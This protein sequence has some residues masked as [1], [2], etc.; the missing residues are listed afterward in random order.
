MLSVI[1]KQC[2]GSQPSTLMREVTQLNWPWTVR[3]FPR[4]INLIC[5]Y[6]EA[7]LQSMLSVI[8]KQCA[9]IGYRAIDVILIEHVVGRLCKQVH[10]HD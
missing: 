9:S 2:A 6:F 4:T 1:Y 10:G 3:K 8:Y 5:T 7:K